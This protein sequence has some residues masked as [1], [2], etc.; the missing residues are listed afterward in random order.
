MLDRRDQRASQLAAFKEKAKRI[1]DTFDINPDAQLEKTSWIENLVMKITIRSIGVAFPLT[2][3]EDL[4]L[5][6]MRS[7]ESIPVQAFL[8]SIKSID[9]GVDHG[10]SGQ[11]SMGHLSFQFV[12]K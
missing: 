4:V 8:F 7:R 2:H 5:P 6:S 12:S 3:D 10:K 11:A 1:L 9:F